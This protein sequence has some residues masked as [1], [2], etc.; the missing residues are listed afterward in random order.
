M[1]RA[2]E[3]GSKTKGTGRYL[4]ELGPDQQ[5]ALIRELLEPEFGAM[6]VTPPDIEERVE[7]LGKVIARGI[8]QAFCRRENGKA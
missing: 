3:M 1:T 5:Y 6:F 8:R 2:L 4:E 7:I